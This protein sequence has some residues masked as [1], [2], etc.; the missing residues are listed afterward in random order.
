[1]PPPDVGPAF[2]AVVLSGAYERVH[3]A[4]VLAATAAALGRPTALFFTMSGCTTVTRDTDGTPGWHRLTPT[5][6]HP[7]AAAEDA[8]LKARGVAD[9]ETLLTSVVALGGAVLVCEAGLPEGS[10]GGRASPALKKTRKGW[11]GAASP[12]PS[13]RGAL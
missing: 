7:S 11:G 1:M 5:P 10:W 8:A 12:D 3:H 9:L 13:L 4:L 6:S 2:R